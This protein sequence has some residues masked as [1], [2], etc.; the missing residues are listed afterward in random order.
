MRKN[1]S[2]IFTR[3]QSKYPAKCSSKQQLCPVWVMQFFCL[4][5]L[6]GLAAEGSRD[7]HAGA[8]RDV[9]AMWHTP[10]QNPQ[11]LSLP[12]TGKNSPEVKW[13]SKTRES[14]AKQ[15]QVFVCRKAQQRF[16]TG[17][18]LP[19]PCLWNNPQQGKAPAKQGNKSAQG[20]AAQL[21]F[22]K[23]SAPT[24]PGIPPPAAGCP[25]LNWCLQF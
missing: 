22:L 18:L 4:S 7:L 15:R 17:C 23:L 12:I 14:P 19:H 3:K 10:G 1:L 6:A 24:H 8:H 25:C 9:T 21:A 2:S 13:R 20:Q 11:L 5:P 16:L